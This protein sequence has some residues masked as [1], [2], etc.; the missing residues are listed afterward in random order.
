MIDG[1]ELVPADAEDCEL[2]VGSLDGQVV[3]TFMPP[4]GD[5][6]GPMASVVLAPEA[7]LLVAQRL[8]SECW[9]AAL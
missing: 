9:R 7:A 8:L 5:T 2:H 6:S 4:G 3:L 1:F